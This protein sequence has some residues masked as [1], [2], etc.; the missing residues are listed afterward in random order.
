MRYEVGKDYLF[1]D[2]KYERGSARFGRHYIP[3]L[4]R[5]DSITLHVLKCQEHHKVCNQFDGEGVAPKHDGFIFTDANGE[6]WNNQYPRANYGQLDDSANWL[7]EPDDYKKYADPFYHLENVGYYLD[8]ILRGL[9]QV[10]ASADHP[11]ENAEMLQKHFDDVVEQIQALGY[12]V[13]I[14]PMVLKKTDGTET[15][16]HEIR[17]VTITRNDQAAA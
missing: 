4:D 7:V 1:I 3:W 10:K 2:V 9:R 12:T 17:K 11:P 15:V 13:S 14:G 5:L 8:G 6:L 16:A